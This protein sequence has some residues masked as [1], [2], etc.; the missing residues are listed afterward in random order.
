MLKKIVFIIIFVAVYAFLGIYFASNPNNDSSDYSNG[1]S[2]T[3]S[4]YENTKYGFSIDLSED[5]VYFTPGTVDRENAAKYGVSLSEIDDGTELLSFAKPDRYI[6]CAKMDAALTS[7][8][9][10]LP[11]LRELAYYTAIYLEGEDATVY[12]YGAGLIGTGEEVYY[13]YI[14]CNYFGNDSTI[15]YVLFNTDKDASILVYGYYPLGE[16]EDFIRFFEKNLKLTGKSAENY[17]T[18]L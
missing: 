13:Y 9:L 11:A 17:G 3:N 5:W 18:S 14:D 8:E 1:G 16:K 6:T 7:K 12:D 10:N 4:V 15:L 2:I